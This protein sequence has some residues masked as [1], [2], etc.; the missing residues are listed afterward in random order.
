[1]FVTCDN[2][3]V[4]VNN[5]TEYNMTCAAHGLTADWHG[6]VNYTTCYSEFIASTS[7]IY[8]S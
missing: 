2:N 5:E 6:P 8:L 3:T 7:K 4:F 1:M